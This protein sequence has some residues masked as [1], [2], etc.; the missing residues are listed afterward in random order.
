[1]TAARRNEYEL[2]AM[3]MALAIAASVA[4]GCSSTGA[5]GRVSGSGGR[6]GGSSAGSPGGGA[7]GDNP[8][9]FAGQG[10][11]KG[12]GGVPGGAGAG[13]GGQSGGLG[14]G[15]SGGGG[16]S[17]GPGGGSA[18]AG[19]QSGGPGGGPAS[20]GGQSGGPGGGGGELGG[21]GGG[22]GSAPTGGVDWEPWPA[23]DVAP[24]QTCA[25]TE[26]IGGDASSSPK[27]TYKETW[28]YDAA[29]RILTRRHEARGTSAA[30]IGYMRLDSQA[31]REM[32]CHAQQYF[33][34]ED[35]TRD[36]LGNSTGYSLFGVVTGPFDAS[37][38]DPAHPPVKSATPDI[39]PE[40]E[41]HRLT[42]DSSGRL[43][44][45]SYVFP[46][47]GAALSFARDQQGR[48]SDVTW[49]IPGSDPGLV[50][51][52]HEVDHWTY[53]GDKLT[54]RVVTNLDDPTDVRG[55]MSYTYDADGNLATTVVD[56][57]LDMPQDSYYPTAKRD[58]VTD[59]VVRSVKLADGSRW[60][61]I[62]DFVWTSPN[63][64]LARDGV[65]TRA[66]R[67][68]WN[69]S[70]GCAALPLPKHTSQ[71][72]E[73]ERPTPMMPL[74]W[75]NPLMTPLPLWMQSPLPD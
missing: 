34:C 17:G 58:G 12:T 68:R 22:G 4:A 53:V 33:D 69:F 51:T 60:V 42:Y 35:W 48:C 64:T 52:R 70:P 56:G 73:F 15:S 36:T 44:T 3:V 61:E 21:P 32:I 47:S 5:S 41:R 14:G 7:S 9:G 28:E 1:M 71:D 75:S 18:G 30:W 8:G 6:G 13:G 19:G 66:T 63:A 10:L 31:R 23:V 55:V 24:A 59:Y 26:F 57:R 50:P 54:S 38:L 2:S 27:F 40:S 74:G 20:A 62:V 72:C 49:S 25:V 39:G 37:I 45:A 43:A 16:Q 29:G 65:R 67:Y 46:V 11:P